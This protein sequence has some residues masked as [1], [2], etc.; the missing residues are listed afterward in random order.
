MAIPGQG[1]PPAAGR[2]RVQGRYLFRRCRV[3]AENLDSSRASGIHGDRCLQLSV[4]IRLYRTEYGYGKEA[5]GNQGP[6][7]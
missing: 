1:L 6:Y 2:E 3:D 7:Y 4:P 5:E